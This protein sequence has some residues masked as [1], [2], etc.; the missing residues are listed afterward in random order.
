MT[1]DKNERESTDENSSK[2]SKCNKI[3]D[4]EL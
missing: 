2:S 1:F 3:S 4:H